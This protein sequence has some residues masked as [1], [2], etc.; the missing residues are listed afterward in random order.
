MQNKMLGI[1][2]AGHKIKFN[3]LNIFFDNLC[4]WQV[5]KR[6]SNDVE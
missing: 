1:Y 4:N 3:I 2:F 6:A 5:R